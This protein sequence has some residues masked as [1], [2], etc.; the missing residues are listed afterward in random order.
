MNANELR[1]G[2]LVQLN[3]D[4]P[5]ITT[6]EYSQ[7]LKIEADN[8]GIGCF[9]DIIPDCDIWDIENDEI[10]PIPLTKV[11]LIDK[12][13]LMV[14]SNGTIL[15]GCYEIDFNPINE[16]WD[17]MLKGGIITSIKYVHQLQNLYF[18]LSGEE[19]TINI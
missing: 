11:W 1:I 14:L 4:I 2:N 8:S 10:S 17:V 5:E 6:I 12:F 19:L 15:S 3:I 7:V 9:S 16:E 18:A 13:E